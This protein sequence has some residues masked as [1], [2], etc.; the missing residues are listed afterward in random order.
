MLLECFNKTQGRNTIPNFKSLRPNIEV[1]SNNGWHITL[2][3]QTQNGR[4]DCQILVRC[5]GSTRWDTIH[6]DHTCS[7]RRQL[8][9]RNHQPTCGIPSGWQGVTW[10]PNC[11]WFGGNKANSKGPTF[12]RVSTAKANPWGRDW[13][14]PKNAKSKIVEGFGIRLMHN[15][16]STGLR[17]KS[18]VKGELTEFPCSIVEGGRIDHP[19]PQCRTFGGHQ[20]LPTPGLAGDSISASLCSDCCMRS[21]LTGWAAADV[22]GFS[23]FINPP[24]LAS[25]ALVWLAIARPIAHS[26]DASSCCCI[27]VTLPSKAFVV[28]AVDSRFLARC[29]WS[30]LICVMLVSNW[31]NLAS[32]A[33]NLV[34]VGASTCRTWAGPGVPVLT[35]RLPCLQSYA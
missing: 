22:G 6:R 25:S 15:L 34:A 28:P 21:R 2:L 18:E 27:C 20:F 11:N 24:K 10:R 9:I 26:T 30:V 7:E 17:H 8:G 12:Q 33:W 32:M 35:R 19:H 3:K 5:L 16:G 23:I 13:S 31:A 4:P 14:T 1:T 29:C